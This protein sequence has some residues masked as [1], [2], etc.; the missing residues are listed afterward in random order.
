MTT[1][2]LLCLLTILLLSLTALSSAETAAE[3]VTAQELD[4]FLAGLRAQ[5][6]TMKALNEPTEESA[7]SEDGIRIQYENAELFAASAELT[8]QTPVNAVRFADSEG[9]VFR[10]VGI[11]TQAEDLLA[12]FPQEN[13]GLAGTR[14]EAV[15]YLRSTPEAGFVYGRV[16]RDGQRLTA[17]EY[18]EVLPCGE[19]FRGASVTFSLQNGLVTSIR[20]EGLNPETAVLDAS[21]VTELF[22]SLSELSG[23]DEYRAVKTSR[24]GTDL[25]PFGREDLVFGSISYTE[26]TPDTLPGTPESELI[27][28][29]DGTS[30]LRC[31]GDG[32]EAVFL[33]DAKGGNAQIISYS[34]LD[35][36]TEGPRS[37]RLGDLFSEDFC[38]FRSGENEMSEDMTEWLY[39]SEDAVPRGFASYDP[40][41]GETSLRYV[42]DTEG[43]TQVELL[44]KYEDNVLNTLI[45]HTL[46]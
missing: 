41:A 20:M 5:V 9:E 14:D 33:C 37:V 4:A 15:L 39:G 16:L 40:S 46:Q 13:E 18:G 38:R 8:E 22:A 28:N 10:G 23:T 6:A 17:A 21:D 35:D 25:E 27:D 44:L 19:G 31:D 24:T 32:Y 34:I 3:P 43:G 26:L 29:G 1:R 42:T 12:A 7:L 11:D 2:K 36:E 45:I 30:L